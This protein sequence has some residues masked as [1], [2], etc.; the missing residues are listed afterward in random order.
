MSHLYQRSCPWLVVLAL[1]SLTNG[2]LAQVSLWH[3]TEISASH[4]QADF[5]LLQEVL[6]ESHGG[7]HVYTSAEELQVLAKN[8]SVPN[9]GL[10]LQKAYTLLAQYIDAIH[11]GHTWIMPAEA[12]AH[13][14]LNHAFLP[15]TVNVHSLDICIDQNY[16]EC[17]L[18]KPGTVLTAI[19]GRPVREIVRELLPY[20]TAD[21]R[22]LSGKLGGL[23]SQFWWYYSLHYGFQKVHTVAFK[24][25]DGTVDESRVAAMRMNDRIND[26]NEIYS[27]YN[28]FDEPVTWSVR[29]DAALLQVHTF[30][31]MSLRKYKKVFSEA[32]R[33]F[34][35]AGCTFLIIDIRGN[36]GGR[37]GVENLL[38]S[39]LGQSCEE[40][41]DAVEIR[42]PYAHHYRHFRQSFQRRA[43]DWLY[44]AVEF[45]KND[46]NSWE[47]RTRFKRSFEVVDD[48]FTGPVS[49]LIDRNTFSGA[50]EFAALVRDNIPM[51]ILIG[52]ETCGGY[53]GHTSGY[54][55]ELVLPNTGFI[56]HIPRIWFDL[57]VT[58]SETGGVRP[59]IHISPKMGASEDEVLIFA[60]T[61]GW[62]ESL[63]E[64]VPFTT[65]H[66]FPTCKEK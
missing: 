10:T 3:T 4:F 37:E 38:L 47:R 17:H 54:A 7:L 26:L 33:D 53:Q 13:E 48:P 44:T 51:S 61:G 45:R 43:E 1:L 65:N 20:F 55:Y 66:A 30:G 60:L 34:R 41:Y 15:F 24:R 19:D 52:E 14:M 28:T 36:G 25:A 49:V 46:H 5:A 31:G 57:N 8:L 27:R 22:S 11:D 29:G 32:L 42:S 39:C 50:A 12:H 6:T 16:S 23:E 64:K 2:A 59:H 56:V 62:V 18:L 58:G 9:Q 35:N 63:E 21:G 40:K